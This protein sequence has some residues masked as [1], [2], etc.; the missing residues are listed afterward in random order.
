MIFFLLF[1]LIIVMIV[2]NTLITIICDAFTSVRFDPLTIKLNKENE[3]I[4]QCFKDKIFGF[5]GI[6][7]SENEEVIR[8]K[9]GR[10][11]RQN[12]PDYLS[13][14]D[15]FPKTIDRLT[16]FVDDVINFLIRYFTFC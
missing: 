16:L 12:S 1:H 15:M 8:D 7:D 5:F 9:N 3:E 14:A 2:V 13:P 11:I 6:G 4:K 10:K